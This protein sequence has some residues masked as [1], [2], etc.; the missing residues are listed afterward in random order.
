MLDVILLKRF[1]RLPG[2]Q[3]VL[4]GEYSIEEGVTGR[5]FSRE[6]EWSMC[7]RPG[8][9]IDMSMVFSDLD[10]TSNCCPRC[11]TKSAVSA[12]TRTQW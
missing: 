12:E 9:K 6:I 1:E 8:Q 10:A 11:G 2:H 4:K 3:K 7:F 5:D